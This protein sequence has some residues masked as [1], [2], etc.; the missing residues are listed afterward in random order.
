MV[1]SPIDEIKNRLDIV[2]VVQKYIKLKKAGVNYTALCPFHSEKTPSFFVSPTRQIWHCFGCSK[3][4]DIFGF[5]KEIE[6]VEFGDALRILA[7]RAG[8]E[9]KKQDPKLKTERQRLYEICELTAKFF[10]KQLKDSQAGIRA[11][12]YLL[13]RGAKEESIKKWRLGYAPDTWQ[14]LGDFLVGK[15]Y[16]KEEIINAG[17]IIRKQGVSS[18]QGALRA[19]DRFRSRIMFPI[20]DFNGQ[21]IGFT[22][23]IFEQEKK[24]Q[25]EKTGKYI[26]TPST[27]LYN[28]SQI[29][30]GLDKAKVAIRKKDCCLLVE[31]QMD[32]IML[33]QA[34]FD[35][36]V[37]VSGTALTDFQLKILKRYS[38]NLLFAFD[39]DEGGDV[40]TK[41]SINSALN[42]DFNIKVVVMPKDKDPADIISQNPKTFEKLI[43]SAHSIMEF[44]F[45]TCFARFDKKTPLGRKEITKTLLPIIKRISNKIEQ[46]Y[47]IQELGKRLEVKEESID[48]ELKKVK[49]GDSEKIE[50][51]KIVSV[52]KTRKEMIEEKIIGLSLK[53]PDYLAII[54]KDS[55]K[56]FSDSGKKIL[57]TLKKKCLKNKEISEKII[58]KFFTAEENDFLNYLLLKIE[59]EQEK[60]VPSKEIKICLKE[61]SCLGIKTELN[62]LSQQIKRAEQEKKF[63]KV[64]SLTKEFI[65]LSQK[66]I[67]L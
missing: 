22:G 44:Y 13:G 33:T 59:T 23:R 2:E 16:K 48:E 8:V 4:G 56:Y 5:V 34:G 28:K 12:K 40:A 30:Y 18:A 52:P 9:L 42:Y 25:V 6:G 7:D 38:S 50:D 60:I 3:G 29:I 49:I 65:K 57:V 45:K 10:E 39:M 54:D 26:N 24:Q 20:F 55:L 31:G 35:N 58:K 53:F 51:K 37:A 63:S 67:N 61:L 32:V 36:V 1:N 64:N 62:E 46:S 15:G 43:K 47:W 41:Q 19:Y 17:L 66:L 21:V 14:G 27:L 11:K